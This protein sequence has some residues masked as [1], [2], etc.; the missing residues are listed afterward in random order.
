MVSVYCVMVVPVQE[1]WRRSIVFSLTAPNQ[2]YLK[3]KRRIRDRARENVLKYQGDL[4]RKY[5]A[6]VINSMGE[7]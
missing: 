3:T 1:G 5:S 2:M 4:I 6:H 7:T